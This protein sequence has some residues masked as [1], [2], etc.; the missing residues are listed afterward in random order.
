MFGYLV[1]S[2]S[3]IVEARPVLMLFSFVRV[4]GQF[5]INSHKAK[6]TAKNVDGSQESPS[7]LMPATI[8]HLFGP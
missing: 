2:G 5:F 3:Y 6:K 8:I 1:N 7:E 4:G